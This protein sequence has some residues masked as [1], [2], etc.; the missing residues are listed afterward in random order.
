MFGLAPRPAS[1]YTNRMAVATFDTHAAVKALVRAGVEPPHAEAI[2]DTVR[3]ALSEGVATKADLA[4]LEN[5]MLKVAIGV[6]I[7][8]AG[9]TYAI[10][11]L[12][13]SGGS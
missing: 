7:A 10:L 8:N 3:D 13:L 9:V 6:V 2:T 4:A 12:V 11:K 5:R 1:G